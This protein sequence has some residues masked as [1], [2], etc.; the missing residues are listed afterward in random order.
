MTTKE[1]IRKS[2][3]RKLN[4]H[5]S[6]ILEHYSTNFSS[7]P[8]CNRCK[9]V[10]PLLNLEIHHLSYET[11]GYRYAELVC[12]PCHEATEKSIIPSFDEQ[13]HIGIQNVLIFQKFLSGFMIVSKLE[14]GKIIQRGRLKL[15]DGEEV[16]PLILM[17][18]FKDI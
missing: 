13:K 10:L 17:G 3:R 9:K 6:M 7:E 4:K 1:T 14:D 16:K 5:H 8:F 2:D 12:R 18:I 15:R 11:E